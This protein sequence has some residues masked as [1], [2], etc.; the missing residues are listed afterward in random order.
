M[1]TPAPS[2][3]QAKFPTISRF[4][5]AL[6]SWKTL[7]RCLVVLAALITL[8]VAWY[9]QERWRG[10]WAWENYR[11]QLAARGL[12]LD[13]K[14]FAPPPVP[15][16]QNFAMTPFLAP[17][18]DFNPQPLQPG[19]STWRDT[20]GMNRTTDFAK[21]VPVALGSKPGGSTGF[22]LMDQPPDFAAIL[23]NLAELTNSG[24]STGPFAS[25]ADAAAE[26][27]KAFAAYRP[28]LDELR[29]ASRRP[30]SRFN[31]Q[32]NAEDPMSILLPHLGLL[33]RIEMVLAYQASAELA[34]GKTDAAFA[35]V[36]FMLY[37]PNTIRSEPT[38]ISQLVRMAML[39]NAAIT[40][41][42]GLAAHAWSADQLHR[43]QDEFSDVN[44]LKDMEKPL[45]GERVAFGNRTLELMREGR[46]NYYADMLGINHSAQVNVIWLYPAGWTYFDE[47]NYNQMLDEQL[48]GYDPKGGVVHPKLIDAAEARVKELQD[49]G[50][51]SLVFHHRLFA[52]LAL[53]YWENLMRKTATG[54]TVADECA[55]ACAL[56][57]Y[58]LA[59]GKYPESLDAL[60][61]KFIAAIPH[62]V[63]TGE[64][65]KYRLTGD[66]QFIIYSI[67]WN[68]T[69]DGG[70]IVMTADGKEVDATQGDWVWPAYAVK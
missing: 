24:V 28:V 4:C 44:V 51:P 14:N 41:R 48:T 69:D 58:R 19:Q 7:R 29:A 23:R 39:E 66:G 6:F 2:A 47:L 32:Y 70:K 43:F 59:N 33:R 56:E 5:R 34:T 64:P 62:D 57:R 15:D 40:V 9:T 67:G 12:E 25:R 10:K 46:P 13:W 18:F 17:L 37:L 52:T 55:V 21:G 30:F 38:I 63:I 61:P 8:I 11:S 26:L 27:L 22:P 68:E 49:A 60:V 1:E 35:D 36:E 3:K 50:G 54:Q 20:N 42:E 16:D 53:S 65:L 31:L 45:N